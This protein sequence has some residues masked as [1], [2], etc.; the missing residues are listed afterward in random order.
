MVKGVHLS[1]YKEMVIGQTPVIIGLS[2]CRGQFI[3]SS[4]SLCM[5]VW[6]PMELWALRAR[7]QLGFRRLRGTINAVWMLKH[8][9]DRAYKPRN[10]GGL[11]GALFVC[12]IDIKKAFDSATR[13]K[14]WDRLRTR[15]V[16]GNMLRALQNMYTCTD[17]EVRIGINNSSERLKSTRGV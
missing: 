14:I 15:G 2:R 1:L 5:N 4:P 3:N 16:H 17:F 9:I 7:S 6:T 12:F 11:G 8:C 10:V 13:S